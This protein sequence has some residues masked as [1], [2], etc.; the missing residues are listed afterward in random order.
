MGWVLYILW[1]LWRLGK[2]FLEKLLAFLNCHSMIL[3]NKIYILNY[4]KKAK[5]TCQTL[6][7]IYSKAKRSVLQGPSLLCF[8][9]FMCTDSRL[10]Q[11]RASLK[12]LIIDSGFFRLV[13]SDTVLCLWMYC[14]SSCKL[15][16]KI[17]VRGIRLTL[18]IKFENTNTSLDQIKNTFHC[19]FQVNKGP[20]YHQDL[21]WF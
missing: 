6:I 10:S 8:R 2:K 15:F 20:Y 4:P 16:K 12:S 9:T 5:I 21:S 11:L 7:L 3:D 13:T 14:F 17:Y 1:D 19:P 18:L